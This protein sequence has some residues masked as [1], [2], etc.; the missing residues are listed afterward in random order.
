MLDVRGRRGQPSAHEEQSEQQT[1]GERIEMFKHMGHTERFDI[2][3]VVGFA[4]GL[5]GTYGWVDMRTEVH[6]GIGN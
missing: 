4:V 1:P 5:N 3:I 2:R 6:T